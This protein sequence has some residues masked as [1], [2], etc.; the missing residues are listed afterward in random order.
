MID[1]VCITYTPEALFSMPFIAGILQAFI[2]WQ[3]VHKIVISLEKLRRSSEDLEEVSSM[4]KLAL[5]AFP[6]D[7]T[8]MSFCDLPWQWCPKGP[9]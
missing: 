3:N 9:E 6:K 8:V 1:D 7:A 5:T 4:V 2:N